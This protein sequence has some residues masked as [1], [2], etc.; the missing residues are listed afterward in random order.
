MVV[1]S[2]DIPYSTFLNAMLV[3]L[4]Y[5]TTGSIATCIFTSFAVYLMWCAIKGNFAIGIRFFIFTFYPVK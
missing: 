2:D 5:G 3:S 1:V 4:E